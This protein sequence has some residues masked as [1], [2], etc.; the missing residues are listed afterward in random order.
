ML[1]G[2]TKEIYSASVLGGGAVEWRQDLDALYLSVAEPV[3]DGRD[4]I[5]MLV[6]DGPDDAVRP[7]REH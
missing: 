4:M 6:T 3:L 2:L 5:V 1:P 7:Y